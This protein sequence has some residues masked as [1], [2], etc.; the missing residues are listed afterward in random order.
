MSVEVKSEIGEDSCCISCLRNSEN[1]TENSEI[2]SDVQKIYRDL[3]N[4]EV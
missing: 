2:P 4:K 1:L 3:L